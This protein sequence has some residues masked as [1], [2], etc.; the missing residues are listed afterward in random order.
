VWSSGVV[1][2]QLLFDIPEE[3]VSDNDKT[4]FSGEGFAKVARDLL[5]A[6]Q[7]SDFVCCLPFPLLASFPPVIFSSHM[8]QCLCVFK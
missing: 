1:F 6:K 2:G 8:Y 5:T 3:D 7:Q 4:E